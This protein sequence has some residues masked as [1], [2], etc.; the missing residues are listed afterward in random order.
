M[1]LRRKPFQGVLNRHFILHVYILNEICPMFVKCK[2]RFL[3]VLLCQLKQLR[4]KANLKNIF[5]NVRSLFQN[6]V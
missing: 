5:S 2:S 4:G 3:S 6:Y 1:W